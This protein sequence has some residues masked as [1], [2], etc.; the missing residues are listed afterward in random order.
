MA[1]LKE[2]TYLR[3]E[4]EIGLLAIDYAYLHMREIKS[5]FFASSKYG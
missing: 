1:I 5:I 3:G 2:N 4:A